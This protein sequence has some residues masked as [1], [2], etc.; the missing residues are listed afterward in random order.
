[1]ANGEGDGP[2]GCAATMTPGRSDGADTGLAGERAVDCAGP[3][4]AVV[5]TGVEGRT[6]RSGTR[7]PMRRG[8]GVSRT[9][10]GGGGLGSAAAGGGVDGTSAGAGV[11][12]ARSES[13]DGA[14]VAAAGTKAV[15]TGAAALSAGGRGNAGWVVRS[16]PAIGV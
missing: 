7:L 3:S 13:C 15:G 12:S 10:A 1:V 14:R 2:S 5:L 4:C 8:A 6:A 11:T 9:T 16:G